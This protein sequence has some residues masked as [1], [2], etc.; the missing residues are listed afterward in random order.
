LAIESAWIGNR[1]YSPQLSVPAALEFVKQFEGG[2]EGIRKKNHDSVVLRGEMLAK[3]WDTHLGAPP[4]LCSAMAMVG[5]PD[6]LKV[7]SEK[8]AM[9]LRTRLRK[10]FGV[11]VPIYHR[12]PIAKT[13]FGLTDS[14]KSAFS[15]YARISHQIYNTVDDYQKFRDAINQLVLEASPPQ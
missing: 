3:A 7:G 10:E 5:L 4:E 14:P 11:E 9:D 2:I 8:D 12:P 15:A 1:D 13:D 6:S